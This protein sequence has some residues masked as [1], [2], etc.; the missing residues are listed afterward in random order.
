MHV[1]TGPPSAPTVSATADDFQSLSVMIGPPELSA[2]CVLGYVLTITEDGGTMTTTMS[3]DK[4]GV[5]LVGDLNLCNTSYSFT[6][7]ATTGDRDGDPS[8]PVS[9]QVD[10]S[11]WNHQ[12]IVLPML[13]IETIFSV[14]DLISFLLNVKLLNICN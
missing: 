2:V 1:V 6:A 14:S 11:G 7:Y 8:D 10:F 5:A 9:G 13:F 3:V 12:T 4:S